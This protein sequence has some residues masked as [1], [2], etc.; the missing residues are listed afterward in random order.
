MSN[1]PFTPN[2][3]RK[4]ARSTWTWKER[5]EVKKSLITLM[6]QGVYTNQEIINMLEELFPKGK[7]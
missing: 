4:L 6:E 1:P 3:P 7:R 2:S 5:E